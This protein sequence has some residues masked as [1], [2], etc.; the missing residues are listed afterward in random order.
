VDGSPARAKEDL[1]QRSYVISWNVT[2]RCNEHCAHCYIHAGPNALTDDE[3]TTAECFR[4]MDEIHAVSPDA[5]LILT[6]GEPLLRPDIFDLS[7]YATDA[8]FMVVMGTNGVLI[9]ARVARKMAAAGVRGVAVSIDSLDSA[10]HDG[11]RGYSGAWRNSVRGMEVLRAAGLPFLVQT[12]VTRENIA[13]VPDLIEWASAQG[14]KV[15]NLYFLV[16]TGR[17][18]FMS[19]VTPEEHEDLMRRLLELQPR[20]AGR[21]L[22]NAKCAPH[23]QRVLWESDANHPLLKAFVGAGACPAGMQYMGIRPNGDMTPCPYLP[24]YGGN[25]RSQSFAAIWYES[26]VFQRIRQRDALG[27]RCGPCEFSA[28]CGGCRARAYGLSGDF[29]AEDEWCTY[30]PGTYGG[31]RIAP[32]HE[33][34]GHAI[35]FQLEWTPEA[36]ERVGVIPGFVRGKVIA[37]TEEW[38]RENGVSRITLE[39]MHRARQE[40]LGGRVANVPEFVQRLMGR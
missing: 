28:M 36:R 9:T 24:V 35:G 32:P 21:M 10:V 4:V 11:F 7:R 30:A 38:A 19:T 23:F 5:M 27:G 22:I 2:R 34:Y 6:G 3:L 14:A 15:F 39:V 25:L 33:A 17:G 1:L 29:M 37:G 31:E 13:E 26:E 12:T 40:R 16:P 8:G 20:Y 18:A